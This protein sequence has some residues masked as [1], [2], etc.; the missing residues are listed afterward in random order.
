MVI[1]GI[2]TGIVVYRRNQQ[3]QREQDEQQ[4]A[5]A[6]AAAQ[7][8]GRP[9]PGGPPG[10]YGSDAP[11]VFLPPVQPGPGGPPPGADPYGLLSGRDHPDN[12]SLYSGDPA[13]PTEVLGPQGYQQGPGPYGQPLGYGGPAQGYGPPPGPAGI[14]CARRSSARPAAGRA[15]RSAHPGDA[16]HARAG[17][18]AARRHRN[19]VVDARISGGADD[20]GTPAWAPDFDDTGEPETG[21]QDDRQSDRWPDEVT[22]PV[23][24]WTRSELAERAMPTRQSVGD[25]RAVGR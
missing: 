5:D 2:V 10:P 23:V 7:A 19:A 3:E 6:A 20:P 8:A 4:I 12:P 1:A 16:A 17:T 14:R 15:R 21:G 9:G 13:G 18:G 11:T 25:R 22:E 24:G